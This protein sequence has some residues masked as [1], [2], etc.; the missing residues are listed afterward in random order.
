MEAWPRFHCLMSGILMLLPAAVATSSSPW[1]FDSSA[2]NGVKEL[3]AIPLHSPIVLSWI[4]TPSDPVLAVTDPLMKFEISVKEQ[5]LASSLSWSSGYILYSAPSMTL[6]SNLTSQFI[7]RRS[8]KWSI[9]GW[10]GTNID[11][12]TPSKWSN[13][14]AF[15]IAPT[16]DQWLESSWIGGGSELRTDW[17]IPGSKILSA[18]AHVSGVGAF[19]LHVNGQKAP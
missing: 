5:G 15:D 2:T 4:A 1:L 3:I 7:P 16:A 10:S 8:Y 14:F 6:P 9:R 18:R 12:L 11:A 19:E 13:H 17:S